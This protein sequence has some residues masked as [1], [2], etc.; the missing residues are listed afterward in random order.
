MMDKRV[1][2]DR[3]VK[4]KHLFQMRLGRSEPAGKKQRS[5]GGQVTQNEPGGI[6]ALTAHPQQILVQAKR[7]IEFAAVHMKY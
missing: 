6:V 1:V 2:R 4:R 7:Q 3:I 5:A